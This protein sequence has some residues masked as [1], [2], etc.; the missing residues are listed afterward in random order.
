M[1]YPTEVN[2]IHGLPKEPYDSGH[3]IGV[4]GHS[5]ANNGD[6]ADSERNY[7]SSHW[8]DAFVHFFVDDQKILQVAD[9]NYVAYGAGHTA[10]HLGYAQVE[11]C[12]ST[13]A[14]KFVKAYAM[15]VWLLAKILHDRK[16]GV[17]DGVT[18][19]SHAQVSVKWHECD[20]T[21]P[22]DYLAS[23]GKTWA[24]LVADVTR[25]YNGMGVIKVKKVIVYFS[26]DDYSVALL[27]ANANGGCAMFNRNR[28]ATVNADA[29][30]AEK[31]IN[32]GG[33]KLGVAGEVYW[34]GDHAADTAQ[35]VL[36]GL[37]GT[38]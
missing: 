27:A 4:V 35:A 21:D 20:H 8:S 31:I 9:I 37:K 15:Y 25:E 1:N 22:I 13:D 19:M 11:L 29:L 17:V 26:S 33:P 30:T 16:L 14:A 34:S 38:Y 7:E 32:I 2:L 23:H 24:S 6:S 5:T 28:G 18:L 12:Q 10:N 3:Y 36:N